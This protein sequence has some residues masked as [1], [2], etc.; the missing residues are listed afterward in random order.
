MFG[1]VKAYKVTVPNFL[2]HPVSFTIFDTLSV[3]SQNLKS[4]DQEC[5][6]FLLV[7]VVVALFWHGP[8]GVHSA[9]CRHQPPQRAVL[10]QIPLG[11][12]YHACASTRHSSMSVY[13]TNLECLVLPFRRIRLGP[14]DFKMGSMTLTKPLV[15][16]IC[17][18]KANT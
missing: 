17:H 13:T 16:V 2:G 18:P 3:I 8:L 14:K 6:P 12:I 9:I 4:H 7:V 15:G 11:V 10:S 1:K 5:I